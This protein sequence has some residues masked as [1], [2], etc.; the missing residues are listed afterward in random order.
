[1]TTRALVAAVAVVLLAPAASAATRKQS[2]SPPPKVSRQMQWFRGHPA[3]RSVARRAVQLGSVAVIG[4]ESMRDLP[5][6]RARYRFEVVRL[7][8]ELHA[9]LVGVDRSL[10]ANAFGDRRIRYLAPLGP[11]RRLTAMPN[12]PLLSSID[13]TTGLPYEWQFA[14]A[15]VDHALESSPGS[16]TIVVGTIDSGAADV[17]D[18]A[19]KVDARWTVAQDGTLTRDAGGNDDV[20]HGTAVASLIA[21]NVDDG[22]GMAGFG[23]ATHV[24]AVRAR[25][26]TDT[27]V[28]VALM[29]LDRLGVRIV[30]MS[31]G[32]EAPDEPI[33]RDAIHKAAAD[34]ILLVAAAGNSAADVAYPAADLQPPGGGPSYGLAVGATDV[35]GNLASFSNSGKRLSLVAPGGYRGPCSGVLVAV[36]PLRD[37]FEN[38]CYPTW[39]GDGGAYYA[40]LAGTSFAAPE[41]AGVAALIW[42]KRP[43]LKNYQVAGIIKQSAGRDGTGWTPAL[44]CGVLDAG[45]A[46]ELATRYPDAGGGDGSCSA[47]DEP[48]P[49]PTEPDVR[50]AAFA[51]PASGRWSGVLTLR[52]KVGEGTHEVAAAV[53]VQRN[54]STV[55]RLARGLFGV[56][57]GPAYGVAWRAP[58]RAKAA[59]RFCVTLT[60]LSGKASAPSCAPISLR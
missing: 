13:S 16:P 55:V 8:P 7:I 36:A 39:A 9:A 29:K 21:A 33:V 46:L 34:G 49:I 15:R 35:A 53:D 3:E 42:A 32:V 41:V 30:N 40:Y 37:A 57:S 11:E 28:A 19:G 54:G 23:G 58:R 43:E 48:P 44:G 47:A 52:F 38:A 60:R 26:L 5:S 18:L 20:G 24:I 4:V 14:R 31:F 22:F 10:A 6:L 2:I 27:E 45:A 50:P 56:E 25:A 59:Y 17:P 12:D 51:L 1:M